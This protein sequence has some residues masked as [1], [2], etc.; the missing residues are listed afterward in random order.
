MLKI[1]LFSIF[2]FILI[3]ILVYR[4][5]EMDEM[6]EILNDYNF[7]IYD[8]QLIIDR[9]NKSKFKIHFVRALI[10]GLSLFVFIHFT[11]KN[12]EKAQPVVGGESPMIPIKTAPF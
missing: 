1:I 12:K 10:F 2:A 4:K 5:R 9:V 3:N 7:N 6:D 11:K 8:S